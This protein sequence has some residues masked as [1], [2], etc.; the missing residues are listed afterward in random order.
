MNGV[1]PTTDTTLYSK[2][3]PQ[4]IDFSQHN[5]YN[6]VSFSSY[7]LTFDV[8]AML[9][10]FDQNNDNSVIPQHKS[11]SKTLALKAWKVVADKDDL[12]KKEC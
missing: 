5:I 7:K 9:F 8:V 4:L 10:T 11:L 1:R 6:S 12:Y 3:S 2:R